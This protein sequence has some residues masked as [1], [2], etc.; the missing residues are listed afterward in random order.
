M[1]K[2]KFIK[3]T[4]ILLLGGFI[5]KLMAL[6]IRI[7]LTRN[8]GTEGLGLYMLILPTFGLFITIANLGLPLAISKLVSENKNNNKK[9]VLPIIPLIIIFNIILIIILIL[10]APILSNNL[11]HNPN[12]K[13]PIIAI[14]IT[15]PFITISDILRGYFF[16]KER[17]WPYTISNNIEQL[18]RLI[19]VITVLP[20][21]L[22][23]SLTTAVV[24][25][26]LFNV[27][28]EGCSIIILLIFS[29]K[30]IKITK[31][32]FKYN[33]YLTKE[34]LSIAIPNTASRLIGTTSSF[35]EPIILMY[36]LN[37]VNYS[38]NYITYEYGI[39]NGYVLPILLLPSFFS[40]AISNALLPIVSNSYANN[41]KKRA[42]TKTK[43][44]IIISLII[45]I[46]ITLI[47]ILIPQ[48]PLKILY[49][50][51]SGTSYI[52]FLAPIFLLHYIQAPLTTT[53][54]AIGKSKCAM[55]GTLISSCIK[56]ISIFI[57]SLFKIGLWGLIISISINIIFV[58]IHH[59]YY[60]NKY[61][62]D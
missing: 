3:S 2:N 46:P 36:T 55:Y 35:L 12:L 13:Y 10:I 57:L 16:G 8:I 19:L 53:L 41:N 15:L 29:P 23:Y 4:L 51:A 39:I 48:I 14:G 52:K 26:V 5:S 28:S 9:I 31:E 11:L 42:R 50:T 17:I 32:D 27:I 25:V 1:L 33:K 6:I 47:F 30:N 49:K 56:I 40:Y 62:K 59:I 60:T 18:I 58:T 34:T 38:P 44:A 54:Q 45:G 22:N 61:L 20:K 37:L 43:E 7:F 21:L 24:G